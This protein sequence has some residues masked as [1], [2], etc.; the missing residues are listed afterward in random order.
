[1]AGVPLA[2]TVEAILDAASFIP[3]GGID[4]LMPIEFGVYAI[5]VKEGASLPEPFQSRLNERDTRVIYIGEAREQSLSKRFLGNELRARGNGTFFRSLSAVLGDRPPAGS[6]A[7]H[8]R[9]PNYRFAPS[10]CDVIVEWISVNL[11]VGWA[12]LAHGNVYAAEVALIRR[13]SPLLNLKDNP[14]ALLELSALRDLYRRIAIG[15]VCIDY[16]YWC[17][18]SFRGNIR[19][20]FTGVVGSRTGAA[21]LRRHTRA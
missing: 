12:L 8:A 14:L 3:A 17:C 2:P 9:R 10:D 4:Q 13:H 1:M 15:E 11:E 18:R 21:A 16:R 19:N 6:R 20:S 7:G 5:G